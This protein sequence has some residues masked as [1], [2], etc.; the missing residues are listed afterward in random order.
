[1]EIALITDQHFGAKNSSLTL[2]AHQEKFY[3]ETFFPTIRERG[4]KTVVD[5]GDAF[6]KRKE[7]NIQNLKEAKRI[8]YDVLADEGIQLYCINGNHTTY[9]RNHVE[10]NTMTELFGQYDNVRVISQVPEEIQIGNISILMIPWMSPSNISESLDIIRASKS[11]V[12]AGHLEINGAF[13]TAGRYCEEGLHHGIFSHFHS[14]FSGHFHTPSKIGNVEYIGNP[15]QLTWSDYDQDRGFSLFD[16]TSLTRTFVPNPVSLYHKI[17]YD[18]TNMDFEDVKKL[19]IDHFTNSYIKCIVQTRNNPYLFDL[20]LENIE[21]KNPIHVTVVDDHKNIGM[22]SEEELID[23]TD[24]TFTIINRYVDSVIE[25]D[26]RAT[27]RKEIHSL[28]DEAMNGNI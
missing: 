11:P 22:L 23:E 5:L 16:T 8:F 17:W 24:D 12:A 25:E 2:L 26:R 7:V 20:F 4:I 19:N 1:M 3:E 6:D 21:S 9:Y 15:Y 10:V 28:Y 18:D 13:M 14:V 27:I